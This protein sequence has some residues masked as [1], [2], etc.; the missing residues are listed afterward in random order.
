MA[1]QAATTDAHGWGFT[2]PGTF[3]YWSG[4][5]IPEQL[6]EQILPTAIASS[7]LRPEG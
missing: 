2:E 4:D 5:R 1:W 3:S 7:V 6:L